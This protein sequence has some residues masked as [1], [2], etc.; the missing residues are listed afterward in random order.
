MAGKVVRGELYQRPWVASGAAA[1]IPTSRADPRYIPPATAPSAPSTDTGLH[2]LS[3]GLM[4]SGSAA[5]VG[6]LHHCSDVPMT[7]CRRAAG[8]ELHSTC[9]H[10]CDHQAGRR[11]DLCPHTDARA[12]CPKTRFWLFEPTQ[13][14]SWPTL[15]RLALAIIAS[16]LPL[17]RPVPAFDA[18]EWR[19]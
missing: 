13:N 11:L 5:K 17:N 8:T 18:G 12:S 10:A 3:R 19:T 14:T 4:A 9:R 1:Q 15:N 16:D 7:P 2:R 6:P